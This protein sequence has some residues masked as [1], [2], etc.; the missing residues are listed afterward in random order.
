MNKRP[1]GDSIQQALNVSRCEAVTPGV[2]VYSVKPSAIS[3]MTGTVSMVLP[4]LIETARET[5]DLH[6]LAADTREQM[7]RE[8][9]TTA[10]FPIVPVGSN[11]AVIPEVA[12]SSYNWYH[13]VTEPKIDLSRVDS[14]YRARPA[15]VVEEK[16]EGSQKA[17]AHVEAPET[18]IQVHNVPRISNKSSVA[19]PMDRVPA[20]RLHDLAKLVLTR[21]AYE[22]YVEPHLA[23]I[24]LE[25]NRALET[26]DSKGAR[27]IV[28]RGYF[29]VVKPFLYGVL[30]SAVKVW[31]EFS[32]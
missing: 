32:R 18:T 2:R 21:D 20:T 11:L 13:V 5:K 27:R 17:M 14:G 23:D 9:L 19:A 6:K 31:L 22:R 28:M 15:F 16:S 8:K 25:Y 26:G 29:E 10:S 1:I 24:W 12:D 3:W 4:S 30:R 7:R